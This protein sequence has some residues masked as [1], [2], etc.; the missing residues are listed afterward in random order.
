M[1]SITEWITGLFKQP[2]P[3]IATVPIPSP[4][5]SS[6]VIAAAATWPE[7]A[8]TITTKIYPQKF[9]VLLPFTLAQECPYP[10]NW[11]NPKN[12]SNDPGD[13]GGK[14]MDGIIQVEYDKWRT[15]HGLPRRD[16]RQM[17]EDEGDDIYYNNY[18]LPYCPELPDGLNMVFFDSAVNEGV[19]EAVKILQFS[20][21]LANDGKWGPRTDATVKGIP[22]V[23]AAIKSFS[24]RR[25][26]VYQQSRG[27][28]LFGK[29]W[30]RRTNEI[31]AAALKMVV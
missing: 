16:V 4:V 30:D 12:F 2:S 5:H 3:T 31:E 17:T 7:K 10:S 11:G 13:P 14:T 25:H 24:A 9:L 8:T 27:Y 6:P 21:G 29:D 23:R 20:L 28:T 1:N 19:T 22:D 15:Q 26:G 18:Y